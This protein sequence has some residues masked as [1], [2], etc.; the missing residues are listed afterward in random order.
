MAKILAIDDNHDNLL[1]LSALLK[2]IIPGLKV[3]ISLSRPECIETAISEQPDTILVNIGMTGADGFE[4]CRKLKLHE[5]ARHI[6]IIMLT[7]MKNNSTSRAKE[8][9]I[10]ADASLTKPVNEAELAAQI[11]AMLGIKKA[12]DFFKKEKDY[13][14]QLVEEK[15]RALVLNEAR[16]RGVF[17]RSKS[18]VVRDIWVFKRRSH[19]KIVRGFSASGPG[20][21]F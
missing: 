17:Y 5:D 8:L 1:S 7:E 3:I 12:E 15:T 4:I 11:Y 10:S 18:G 21:S 6:P 9:E 13:L 16:Y 20:R 19:R 14:E 2:D